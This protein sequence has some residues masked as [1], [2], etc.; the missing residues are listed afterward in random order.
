MQL[1]ILGMYMT[2][3]FCHLP[4]WGILCRANNGELTMFTANRRM[5]LSLSFSIPA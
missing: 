3:A 5:I 1:T 2:K 4:A